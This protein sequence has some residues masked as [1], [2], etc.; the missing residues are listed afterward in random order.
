MHAELVEQG[1][2]DFLVRVEGTMHYANILWT[3]AT[4]QPRNNK[5]RCQMQRNTY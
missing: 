4:H 5:T 2:L 3:E 1:R